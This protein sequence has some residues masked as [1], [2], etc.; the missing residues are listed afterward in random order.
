M[1][2]KYSYKFQHLRVANT[3][4]GNAPHKPILVISL[5]EL[6]EKGLIA[7][8]RFELTPELVAEFKENWA[9]L[10]ESKNNCDFSLP[11]YHLQTDGFWKVWLKTG[12]Q[13]NVH[14]KS[15][16]TLEEEVSHAQLDEEL[17]LLLTLK[18]NR[19]FLL[20]TILDK[21]F[22]GR[23]FQFLNQKRT[24]Q[25]WNLQFEKDI[26]N[27]AEEP[28]GLP[29]DEDVAFI[30]SAKFQQVV[31]RVYNFTC[32]ISGMRVIPIANHSMIDACHIIPFRESGDNSVNNGI[33]LCPNL[34]RAFDRN[35][36]GIDSDYRVVVSKNFNELENHPYSLREFHGREIKLPDLKKYWPDREKLAAMTMNVIGL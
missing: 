34:H 35:L 36:I 29:E 25:D 22:P 9:L 6:I 5:I 30:R 21:Y 4:F 26:L 28:Y 24:A 13:Q 20:N 23:K 3:K 15:I 32:C 31:V 18:T 27:E 12:K 16:F 17:F 10:V 14:I 1:L 2:E 8:N 19:D 7:Q 11:F 33:A